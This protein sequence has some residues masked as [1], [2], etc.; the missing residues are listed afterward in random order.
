MW[1]FIKKPSD[2]NDKLLQCWMIFWRLHVMVF[3]LNGGNVNTTL[4]FLTSFIAVLVVSRTGYQ[5]LTWP[6]VRMLRRVMQKIALSRAGVVQPA[7]R[8]SPTVAPPSNAGRNPLIVRAESLP[9]L[10]SS[11]GKG[12]MTG[13]EPRSM[14]SVSIPYGYPT[15]HGEPGS[16]LQTSGLSKRNATL[17]AKG[18]ELFAKA[19]VKNSLHTSFH[20]FWSVVMPRK[21]APIPDQS[22]KTDIDCVLLFDRMILLVDVKYYAS[23]DVTYLQDGGDR[24]WTIDNTTGKS[25]NKPHK[26]SRN[27]EIAT[28]RFRSLFPGYR[29][30]PLVVLA[31]TDNGAGQIESVVWPGGIPAVDLESMVTYLK[32]VSQGSSV[33]Q[34]RKTIHMIE[35]LVQ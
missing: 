4:V 7:K 3:I 30:Y 32:G 9:S 1:P 5:M 16:G 17:G 10:S 11:T 2:L 12:K 25:V 19:L 13:Y 35:G 34:D 6:I 23:G 24:L 14:V 18:E 8:P 33:S 29:I 15:F 22:L 20:S 31:P 28:E 21:N 27:M 26:M